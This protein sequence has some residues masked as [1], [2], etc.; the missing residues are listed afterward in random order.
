MHPDNYNLKPENPYIIHQTH[1]SSP[2]LFWLDLSHLHFTWCSWGH[3]FSVLS[4]EVTEKGFNLLFWLLF[5]FGFVFLVA[6]G[7]S[8]DCYYC[9]SKSPFLYAKQTKFHFCPWSC[10]SS[11]SAHGCCCLWLFSCL[12]S[13]L[14]EPCLYGLMI[15]YHGRQFYLSPFKSA[16]FSSNFSFSRTMGLEK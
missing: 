15:S 8:G 13:F 4:T 6:C 1:N 10:I 11:S 5:L 14:C 2:Q 16:L 9:I 12:R 7:I 3:Y